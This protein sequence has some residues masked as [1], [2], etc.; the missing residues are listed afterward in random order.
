[1]KASESAI[2]ARFPA[3]GGDII[4]AAMSPML[5]MV[6][7]SRLTFAERLDPRVLARAVRLL[8]DLEPVLGCWYDEKLRG[9]E[10]VRCPDVDE[11]PVFT[12]MDS[13]DRER[14][15][16]AFHAI[17]FDPK[18]PRLAVLHLR[19]QHQDDVCVRFDHVAGDGWSA[20]EVTHLLAETYS[21]LLDD[22]HYAP[23]PRLTPRPSHVDVWNAL[24]DEQREAAA[25]VPR[26][27]GSRWRMKMP[28][29]RGNAFTAR[30]LVLEPK[31]VGAVR[32]Y[33]HAR[34]ATVNEALLA[35]LVRS[36]ASM[37]PVPE[38][39]RPG[40]SVSADPRRLAPDA[41]TNRI[42]MLA[43]TQTVMID[44][45]E[46]ET[47]DETL[48]HVVEGIKP[49]RDC[50]WSIGTGRSPWT[51]MPAA[52]RALFGFLATMMRTF[53]LAGLVTMN[54]G[55]FDEERLAFGDVRPT[56]AIATGPIPK[57]GGFPATI[58]SY[59]DELTIWMGIRERNISAELVER[60]LDGINEQLAVAVG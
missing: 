51:P 26:M 24:T 44:C 7:G 10:W 49:W 23:A 9:A 33:A 13:D 20:K 59:R 39:V 21:R 38:G 32:A 4:G 18:G 48:Q 42:A 16:A 36:A 29:G 17:P 3:T 2:P 52:T 27:T 30:T 47:F 41:S 11:S 50:L 31:R 8:L 6:L 19:S 45:R 53:H 12:T 14:D 35:A 58:S 15:S 25:T 57:F 54:I 1:M 56:S 55:P 5:E 40:V 28:R 34:G 37:F 46:G 60:C 43:T 22:P